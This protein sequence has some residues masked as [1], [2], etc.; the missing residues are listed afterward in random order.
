MR[1]IFRR[2][3]SILPS[4]SQNRWDIESQKNRDTTLTA[5]AI[6]ES[7]DSEQMKQKSAELIKSMPHQMKSQ[8]LRDVKITPAKGE[9]I[10]IK[11]A[12]YTR[13]KKRRRKKK[14]S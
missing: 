6:Q 11:A 3:G 8:G 10:N 1:G 4:Q 9:A 7:L 13:K 5:K 14:K 2:Y 12:Y